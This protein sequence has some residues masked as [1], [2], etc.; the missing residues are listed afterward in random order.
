[1]DESFQER[2]VWYKKCIKNWE[3][4]KVRQYISSY[5]ICVIFFFE[6]QRLEPV[7]EYKITIWIC[8]LVM[9]IHKGY[10]VVKKM[11]WN[12]RIKAFCYTKSINYLLYRLK[13][14]KPPGDYQIC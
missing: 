1:M 9:L 2:K 14:K 10:F 3:K 8:V 4:L 13:K 6:Y 5:Q 7:F 12:V 11:V